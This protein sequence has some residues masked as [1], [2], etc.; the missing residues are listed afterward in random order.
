MKETN[1]QMSCKASQRSCKFLYPLVK[2]HQ[3]DIKNRMNNLNVQE[4]MDFD[5]EQ[6][7]S[8][9]G[10]INFRMDNNKLYSQQVAF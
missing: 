7:K 1:K 10:K 8:H 5:I 6:K 2:K 4:E 9:E 3:I